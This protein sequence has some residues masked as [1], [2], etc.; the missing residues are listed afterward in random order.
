MTQP[1]EWSQRFQE[2]AAEAGQ[3][4]TRVLRRYDELLRRVA[5]GELRPEE[6]QNQFREYLQE[7]AATSTRELVELSVGLLAG[8]LHVEAKY[9]EAL[10][11][12][13]LPSDG[14]VPPPPSPSSIDLTNWF[15]TLAK[16]ATE[17][18]AR[19]MARHQQFVERVAA[20]EITSA[21]M[22][23]QGRRYLEAHA[24]QFLGEVMDLGLTF[25]SRLQQSSTNLT[26]GLYDWVL[27]PETGTSAP[28]PPFIVD[29]RGRSGSAVTTEIVVENTRA[30]AANVVCRVSEF[31]ARG[32]G[33]SFASGA[34][35]V[36]ARFTVA[37]GGARDVTL[38]LPLDRE[39]FTPGADYFAILRISGAGEH[40]MVVQIIAH[41][42]PLEPPRQSE[43]KKRKGR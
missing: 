19:G 21:Q 17:Q 10:L 2:L 41:P 22:Q 5:S 37:P 26:E 30:E 7:Q 24:P 43:P 31:T 42:E 36:P 1:A 14:P 9:R 15:Q 3:M 13:L 35:V 16:Y 32:G 25:V 18:S 11:D 34:E 6:I 12:G 33:R 8:L 23:E 38:S 39:L 28:E 27:G 20:G 40:E 4:Y 29:L